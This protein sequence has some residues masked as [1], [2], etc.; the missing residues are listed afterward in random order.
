MRKKKEIVFTVILALLAFVLSGC[1]QPYRYQAADDEIKLLIRLDLDEDIGLLLI[2]YAANGTEGS[3]GMSN[4]NK[5]MI[6]RDDMLDWTIDKKLLDIP[7]QTDVVDLTAGF[8]VVTEYVDPNYDD[9]YPEEL[10]IPMDA[11]SLKAKF[12]ESYFITIRGDKINGY[13][14]VLENSQHSVI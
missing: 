4:A 8:T 5:S 2:K 7:E 3:G 10:Q 9:I 6:K 12:G 1:S 13:R 11:I 14:A